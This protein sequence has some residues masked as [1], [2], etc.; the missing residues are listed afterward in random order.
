M[1]IQEPS[2]NSQTRLESWKEI[3]AYLQR[4]A[5]TA[6][7]W[8]KEEGLPVHRHTHKSRSS[9]YAYPSEID[10]WRVSRKVVPELAP[11]RPLWKIPAFALTMALCLIMVGNGVRPV[12]AQQAA[13]IQA[14]QITGPNVNDYIT[15]WTATVDN[16]SGDLAIRDMATG[17][18]KRLMA[19]PGNWDNSG[20]SVEGPVLSPDQKQVAYAWFDTADGNYQFRA[21]GNQAGSA[22]RILIRN[23]EYD[24]FQA[25]AWS[26]DSRSV[27]ASVEKKT[28]GWQLAWISAANGSI[29]VL[30]SLGWSTVFG[31]VSLS[32]DGRYI[33]YALRDSPGSPDSSIYVLSADG[34]RET[35]IA[36]GGGVNQAPLWTPDGSHVFFSSNRSG[37]FGL[38]AIAVENG[39]AT[40]P[41]RLMKGDLGN[42]SATGFASSGTFFYSHNEGGSNIYAAE[43]EPA[44][45]RLRSSPALLTENFVGSNESPSWSPDGKL[46][47]FLRERT[48]SYP[49]FFDLVV[50]SIETGVET[51]YSSGKLVRI[52]QRPLWLADSKSLLIAANEPQ[53]RVVFHRFDVRTGELK[54]SLHPE[55]RHDVP[56]P[57]LSPD[58]KTIYTTDFQDDQKTVGIFAL[59]LAGGKRRQV[60][61]TPDGAEVNPRMLSLSPDGKALAFHMTNHMNRAD[62]SLCAI[63][64]DG[65]GF[66]KLYTLKPGQEFGGQRNVAWSHDS[67]AIFFGLGPANQQEFRLMRIPAGGGA[68]EFTGLTMKRMRQIDASPDGSHV[69][70]ASLAEAKQEFWALDNLLFALK[71]RH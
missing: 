31:G 52:R 71:D 67:R 41:A 2:A 42:I 7:R 24:Y 40:G 12:A 4:D 48:S 37:T 29:K 53:G 1:N 51:V 61:R 21:M 20:D 30:K 28:G 68:P 58:G 63:S 8:E 57:V 32:P 64:V 46:I 56:T 3:G 69:A 55:I 39:K 47:A 19:K 59:D 11:P 44:S 9:V 33:A 70:F 36:K 60:F 27:L 45:G 35:V 50:R 66:G 17:Q 15:R 38:W 13:G 43:I 5:T 62:S 54:E 18:I 23:P 16:S 26:N 14:R 22:P 34:S 49:N 10:A 65:T 25:A 6:R